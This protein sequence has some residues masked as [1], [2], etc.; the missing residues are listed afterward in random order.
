MGK[1]TV[2][3]NHAEDRQALQ[4]R[5]DAPLLVTSPI[6]ERTL[7]GELH[8]YPQTAR[9]KRGIK[10]VALPPKRI[11]TQ[12]NKLSSNSQSR[13]RFTATNA[14]EV[15]CSQF[16][17]SY[18]KHL[19]A[20]GREFKKH[21]H[22]FLVVLRR[23]YSGLQYLWLAEFQSRG[24]PHVHLFLNIPATDAGAH[25]F[26][27]RSWARI[28][29]PHNE[30]LLA[31]HLHSSNF[32]AWDMR[33][34]NYLCGYRGKKAQKCIP[35]GFAN[36]GRFWGNSRGLIPPPEIISLADLDNELGW[37][38]VDNN[39]VVT[40]RHRPSV[41]LKRILDRFH[42]KQNKRSFNRNRSGSVSVLTGAP[43][44][45]Q[46]V[47]YLMRQPKPEESFPLK[48]KIAIGAGSL[49]PLS[50]QGT[51]T[52][53]R[54]QRGWYLMWTKAIGVLWRSMVNRGTGGVK[55]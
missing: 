36:F 24:S 42:E 4:P 32:I 8:L 7:T 5:T 40:E 19:P 47:A 9:I 13:L 41:L 35:D 12:I 55:A 6:S 30:S 21:L 33:R 34:G 29:D 52:T 20:D 37:Q 49:F 54:S 50:G 22:N 23:R 17:L 10:S 38:T 48:C 25:D 28:A 11:G 14:G 2:P 18:H 53:C 16:G 46:S 27:A 39:A 31:V 26:I 51:A 15:L 45:R 43:I 44:A 1:C 3:D